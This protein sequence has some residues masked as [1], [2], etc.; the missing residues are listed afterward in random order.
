MSK[1]KVSGNIKFSTIDEAVKDLKAGKIIICVDDENRENEGDFFCSAEKVTSKHVNFMAKHGRGLICLPSTSERFKELDLNLMSQD[2]TSLH[3][4]SFMISIDAKEGT[5]TGISA[6][7][8]ATTIRRFI[9]S[10]ARARDF[11]RPGH[12]FPLMAKD[13]GV[14]RRAGHTEACVDLM[15][16]AGLYPAAVLCEILDED[17][18]MAKLPA[19]SV[20]ARE[21]DLKII[22]VESLI[23]YRQRREKLISKIVSTV[24]P[25]P[26]GKFDAFIY[27]ELLTGEHHLALVKGDVRGKKDVLVRV[28]SQCLTGDVF[29]SLRCDCGSQ[30][31]R[32]L[33]LINKEGCGVFL[34]MRQEGRGIGFGAKMKAYELQDKG[35]DTVEANLALGFPA[36]SRD[37][38]IGAQ[39]LADLGLT[40]IR[41]LTNNPKKMVGLEGYGL[42]IVKRV[43]IEITS[44]SAN[45]NY[46]KTK[47]SKLGHILKLGE[48]K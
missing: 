27:E 10:G 11:A 5:T 38:G 7:D 29:G 48:V 47:R 28:H 15:K 23:R 30:L 35:L 43:P 21:F 2:N 18:S 26:Y 1:Q 16:L 25:T 46:L 24:L 9:E 42:K 22:T 6:H 17:G 3:G 19:L 8:R 14:L 40:S 39:I 41:L 31:Q 37:Y 4:T 33:K 20:L 12:I 36:D 32:A 34:Y 13:G 45:K 44:T